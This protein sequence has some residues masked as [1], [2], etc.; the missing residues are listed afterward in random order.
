MYIYMY[1]VESVLNCRLMSVPYSGNLCELVEIGDFAEK[2]F[3]DCSP[4]PLTVHG[5][6]K[7]WRKK[8]RNSQ[9]F[10]P[11][12]VSRYTVFKQQTAVSQSG[13]CVQTYRS[14]LVLPL[15]SF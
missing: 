7:H 1:V 14:K 13:Y 4:V 12:K 15:L 5:A 8:Q 2:T 11:S 6:F 3:V 10:S 9:K